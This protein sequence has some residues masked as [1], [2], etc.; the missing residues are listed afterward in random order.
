MMLSCREASR[1]ISDAM[2]RK[3]SRYEQVS[4][5]F[6]LLMCSNCRH[7]QLQMATLRA[8]IREGRQR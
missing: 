6:H 3:L 4:L 7:F 8:G 2:D 1:L 5:R